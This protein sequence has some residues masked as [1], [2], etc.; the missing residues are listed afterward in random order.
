ML[1]ETFDL[2]GDY[3]IP[4]DWNLDFSDYDR[5]E[6]ALAHYE[7]AFELGFQSAQL[8]IERITAQLDAY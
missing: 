5:L 7:R 8:K 2:S 6:I 1:A 4:D 3:G